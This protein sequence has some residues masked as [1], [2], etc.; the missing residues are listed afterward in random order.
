MLGC[1]R[2][3][4]EVFLMLTACVVKLTWM[5]CEQGARVGF[6]KAIIDAET[7]TQNAYTQAKADLEKWWNTARKGSAKAEL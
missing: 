5:F 1:V 7:A 4:L 6:N 2:S 3:L